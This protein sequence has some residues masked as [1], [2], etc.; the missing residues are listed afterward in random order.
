[1]FN[2]LGVHL[3]G[4]AELKPVLRRNLEAHGDFMRWRAAL[5]SLPNAGK[6]FV[7][8]GDTVTIDGAVPA[9]DR[10]RL[11]N[12]LQALHPWR[13]GPF[14]LFGMHIDSEWR[15]DLK[16]RRVA[17]HI[18]LRGLRVLDI[19]CGNGYYGWR[20]REAGAELVV[21]I[22]PTVLYCMQHMAINRFI[23]DDRNQVLPTTFEALPPAL[24]AGRFDAAFSMGVIYHRRDPLAHLR[25]LLRCLLP[26]GLAVIESLVSA[27]PATLIPP[28]RY[29]RMRNVWHVPAESQL[30]EWMA[31]CGFHDIRLVDTTATTTRE[32]RSTPWMR[33]DSLAEALDPGDSTLTVEGHPAPRRCVAIAWAPT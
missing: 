13:K 12:A 11:R 14:S 18:E 20:M 25:D 29:A 32:Q 5:D 19:G 31:S 23:Q 6:A 10:G 30:M 4:W 27:G 21:G 1:M 3:P 8:L 16:W 15:S 24:T 7:A 9:N 28:G 33:F 26:G 22:D 2:R 17:P